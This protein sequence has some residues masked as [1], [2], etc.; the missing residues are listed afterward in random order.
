M[1]FFGDTLKG[2]PMDVIGIAAKAAPE[3]GGVYYGYLAGNMLSE[4]L[5]MSEMFQ[6]FSLVEIVGLIGGYSIGR[7]A[8]GIVGDILGSFG[9]G[10]HEDWD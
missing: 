10:G 5:G 6:G 9:G 8:S 4:S 1:G 2:I 3:V 7:D